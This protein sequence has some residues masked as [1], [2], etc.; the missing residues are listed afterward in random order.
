M[1]EQHEIPGSRGEANFVWKCRLCQVGLFLAI[2]CSARLAFKSHLVCSCG[3]FYE[4]Q[5]DNEIW[6]VGKLSM[7]LFINHLKSENPFRFDRQRS[8][9]L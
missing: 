4:A 7:R 9:C 8:A 3:R 6:S 5:G 1:Q 2:I